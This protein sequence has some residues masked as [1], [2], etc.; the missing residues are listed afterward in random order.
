MV[1]AHAW[2]RLQDSD[3]VSQMR[4]TLS[5]LHLFVATVRA[6]G[7]R[8]VATRLNVPRSTVSRRLAL[9]QQRLGVELLQSGVTGSRLTEVGDEY[10]ERFAEVVDG[11]ESLVESV[12]VRA[13]RVR[14]TLRIA[15]SAVFAEAYLSTVLPAYVNDH[16]EVRVELLLAVDRIDLRSAK[17]DVAFRTSPLEDDERTA[18][19]LRESINGFFAA[20]SYLAKHPAPERPADLARHHLIV[21]GEPGHKANWRYLERQQERAIAVNGRVV[22]PSFALTLVLACR[23]VGICRMPTILVDEL[24]AQGR[25]VPLLRPYWHRA[26]ISAVFPKGLASSAKVRVFLERVRAALGA[27]AVRNRGR[28]QHPTGAQLARDLPAQNEELS[29][30]ISPARKRR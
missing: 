17:I 24:L 20:P 4:D 3:I 13:A 5:D 29:R 2:T 7:V 18:I 30:P 16:P 12:G 28:E 27:P 9:F 21:T 19:R 22:S 23:G 14:G 6:G 8:A 15:A 25:L 10:F 11:A 1:A 26:Q